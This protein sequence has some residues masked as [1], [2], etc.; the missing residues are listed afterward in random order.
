M[1]NVNRTA[2]AADYMPYSEMQKIRER[3]GGREGEKERKNDHLYKIEVD[4]ILL[5]CCAVL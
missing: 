5:Q 2:R 1:A 4:I 3:V